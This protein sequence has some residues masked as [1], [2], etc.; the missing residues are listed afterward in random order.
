MDENV[1]K[2]FVGKMGVKRDLKEDG[3]GDKAMCIIYMYG[4][5][6]EQI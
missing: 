6:K 4:I 3:R 2:R 1:R 5:V